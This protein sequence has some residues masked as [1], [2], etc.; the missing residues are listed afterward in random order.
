MSSPALVWCGG[1]P[2]GFPRTNSVFLNSI[3]VCIRKIASGI[4]V[5]IAGNSERRDFRAAAPYW[6]DGDAAAVFSGVG[7]VV[8]SVPNL[9]KNGKNGVTSNGI[10]SAAAV[11]ATGFVL[12]S[13]S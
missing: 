10:F 1:L 12:I 2:V 11:M 6:P 3:T 7:G 13:S 8:F 9:V 5:F 4:R